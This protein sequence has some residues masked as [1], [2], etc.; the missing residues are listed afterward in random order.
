[1]MP[2]AAPLD[3]ASDLDGQLREISFQNTQRMQQF[4]FLRIWT[5]MGVLKLLG[6]S[7]GFFVLWLKPRSLS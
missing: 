7:Q 3:R 1:M 2:L 4:Y 6:F 5:W